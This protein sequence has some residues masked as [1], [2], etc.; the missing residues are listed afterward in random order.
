MTHVSDPLPGGFQE[1][2]KGNQRYACDLNWEA[3]FVQKRAAIF[4]SSLD[5]VAVGKPL[6]GVVGWDLCCVLTLQLCQQILGHDGWIK[7][8]WMKYRKGSWCCFKLCPW[9]IFL[10]YSTQNQAPRDCNRWQNLN[11]TVG[12][13]ISYMMSITFALINYFNFSSLNCLLQYTL[14]KVLSVP[15][16]CPLLLQ[17]YRK[18]STKCPDSPFALM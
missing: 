9:F 1:R 17:S 11:L 12:E 10:V 13:G 4:I 14:W 2:E 18:K 3:I 8:G 15:L 16:K 6:E 5:S 7:V